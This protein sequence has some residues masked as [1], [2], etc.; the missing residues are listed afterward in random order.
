MACSN[1]ET[2]PKFIT[3]Q[4]KANKAKSGEDE[5]EGEDEAES[6]ARYIDFRIC[7]I[8]VVAVA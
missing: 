5:D 3:F 7:Q 6:A 8:V 4:T 2:R 1:F